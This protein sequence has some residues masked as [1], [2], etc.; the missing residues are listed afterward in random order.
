MEC[1]ECGNMST[2]IVLYYNIKLKIYIGSENYNNNNHQNFK[3]ICEK[4][5]VKFLLQRQD[6]YANCNICNGFYKQSYYKNDNRCNIC[7]EN[8]SRIPINRCMDC[9]ICKNNVRNVI[10]GSDIISWARILNFTT[11]SYGLSGSFQIIDNVLPSNSGVMCSECLKSYKFKLLLNV[12]CDR[13]CNSFQ[14]I[15]PNSDTQGNGCASSVMDDCIITHYGSK[16]DSESDNIMFTN[17]RPKEIKYR[18]NL[19]DN[20]ITQLINNG[21]CQKPEYHNNNNIDNIDNIDNIVEF[22]IPNPMDLINESK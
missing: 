20:C 12:K 18:S 3:P 14:S 2:N 6:N 7:S 11:F 15:T 10:N 13:C 16:Y 4:C 9:I 17:E 8:V 1:Y 5:V 19:C 21:V 22:E